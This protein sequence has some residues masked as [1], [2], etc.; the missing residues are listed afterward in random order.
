MSFK[1][2]TG[3]LKVILGSMFAG[4]SSELIKEYNRHKTYNRFLINHIIDDR[5]STNGK[6]MATH[7]NI[8]V[9]CQS[10][11][12]LSEL[13]GEKYDENIINL[14]DVFFINEGQFFVD[15]YV[16][17]D[18]LVNKYNKKVYVCGLDGDY[19]RKNF[20]SILDIIPLCDDI[21]KLKGICTECSVCDSIFTYR[22]TNEKEQT[23]V[24]T[25][26]YISLCRKCYNNRISLNL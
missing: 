3:Y 19:E 22:I 11:N 16:C 9:E 14:H 5:Y 24:S 7:N 8:I 17:V 13:F 25:K 4:K 1:L 26:S 18:I 2:E 6:T 20:G 12:K 21:I 15:L 10:C 23:F